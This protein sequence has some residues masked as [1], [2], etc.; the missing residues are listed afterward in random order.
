MLLGTGAVYTVAGGIFAIDGH[1]ALR[2]RFTV[3]HAIARIADFA[4]GAVGA[5]AVCHAEGSAL[6]VGT[7]HAIFAVGVGL[8]F[9]NT[10]SIGPTK[11]G[12]AN[13][14]FVEGLTFCIFAT[15]RM[16]HAVDA[17]P[18]GTTL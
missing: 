13:V 10:S 7:L 14:V 1:F 17:C 5:I 11:P 4:V 6:C 15:R 3:C 16:A 12:H 8:T 9:R 2:A 18:R